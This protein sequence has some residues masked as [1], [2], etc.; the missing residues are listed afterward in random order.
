MAGIEAEGLKGIVEAA[1]VEDRNHFE[2]LIPRIYE[3]GGTLP[4]D[5]IEFH[6][7]S[8]CPPVNSRW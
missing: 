8:A 3:L 5:M 2:A 4:K 7:I 6:N 1:R